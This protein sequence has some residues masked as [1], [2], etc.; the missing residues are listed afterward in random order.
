MK[1]GINLKIKGEIAYLTINRPK[2]RNALDQQS[3]DDF[4]EAVHTIEANDKVQAVVLT[5]AGGVFCAG[6]DLGEVADGGPSS[7]VS[8]FATG[9]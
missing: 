7:T 4:L 3:A 6:A 9:A 5:G 8:G 2:Q 1:T